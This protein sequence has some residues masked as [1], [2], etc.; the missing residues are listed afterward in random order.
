MS[1][2]RAIAVASVLAVC[3]PATGALAQNTPLLVVDQEQLFLQST[4]GQR[5]REDITRR[6][7]ELAAENRRIESDLVAE[8]KALTEKRKAME[9]DAFHDLANTFDEKVT[10]LRQE[11]DAKTRAIN[12]ASDEAQQVFFS[13]VARIL[14][15]I[16]TEQGALAIL[17]ARVVLLSSGAIDI[18]E[19]AIARIDA[20]LAASDG[21]LPPDEPQDDGPVPQDEP[22]QRP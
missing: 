21:V 9:P 19:T 4:F 17:D 6:S 16:M 8:E 18:T 20:A 2:W 7:A 1:L 13:R 5:M 22:P 14:G 10:T 12:R 11:Q 3:V 15:E